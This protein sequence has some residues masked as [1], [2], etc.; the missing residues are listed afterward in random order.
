MKNEKAKKVKCNESKCT[1][2]GTLD[3][4]LSAANPFDPNERISGCP[5]CKT[6]ESIIS[7]CDEP[8]C[9]AG[10]TCGTSTPKEYRS[11]C[12]EHCPK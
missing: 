8:E 4:M 12:G 10:V 1:W 5:I 11:T 9:W 6:I 2:K 3:E 7:V